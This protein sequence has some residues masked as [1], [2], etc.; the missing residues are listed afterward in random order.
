LYSVE[1]ESIA[2]VDML[3]SNNVDLSTHHSPSSQTRYRRVFSTS[4]VITDVN[5]A[6]DDD[7]DVEFL[8]V[9]KDSNFSSDAPRA[10][11]VK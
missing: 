9:P 11:G 5:D 1:E 6:S 3:L 2:L 4:S 7:D 8:L 10:C